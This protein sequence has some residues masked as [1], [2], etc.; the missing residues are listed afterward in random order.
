MLKF[1]YRKKRSY[2]EKDYKYRFSEFTKDYPVILST[3]HSMLNA[4]L[5][6]H[7]LDYKIREI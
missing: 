7:L 4:I 2:S 1:I 5:R 3:A 6:E